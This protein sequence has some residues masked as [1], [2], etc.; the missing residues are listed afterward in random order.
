MH[1]QYALVVPSMLEVNLIIHAGAS[2]I[3]G[4]QGL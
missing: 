3:G 4:L 2:Q 1:S